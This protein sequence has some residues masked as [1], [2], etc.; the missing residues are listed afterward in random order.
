[1]TVGSAMTNVWVCCMPL[2]NNSSIVIVNKSAVAAAEHCLLCSDCATELVCC[3]FC[4]AI[5]NCHSISMSRLCWRN[6]D[7]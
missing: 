5:K 4:F 1:V 6:Y 2:A 7:I 3:M